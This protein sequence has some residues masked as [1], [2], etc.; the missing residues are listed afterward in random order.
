MARGVLNDAMVMEPIMEP[1]PAAEPRM[2]A[3]VAAESSTS[4][5][6]TTRM[7]W[8]GDP[9]TMAAAAIA[10]SPMMILYRQ[11]NTAPSTVSRATL[12]MLRAP[13]WMSCRVFTG[14]RNRMDTMDST[15][16][17]RNPAASPSSS[18]T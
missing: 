5:E 14:R 3:P 2:P 1:A 7:D 6:K 12:I 4:L 8:Y 13:R 17:S 15:A 16:A 18:V 11:T 10:M 9:K